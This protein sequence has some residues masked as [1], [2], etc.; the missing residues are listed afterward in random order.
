M[1]TCR[2]GFGEGV[3]VVHTGN[4]LEDGVKSQGKRMEV[5]QGK[6]INTR[7]MWVRVGKVK[8]EMGSGNKR[9]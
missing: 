8:R 1:D 2:M 5:E 7:L 9:N 4:K 6:E 3:K